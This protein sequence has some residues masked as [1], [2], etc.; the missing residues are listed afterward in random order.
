M[1]VIKSGSDTFEKMKKK[2]R[3]KHPKARNSKRQA[4]HP[5]IGSKVQG[6]IDM[7]SFGK[8]YLSVEGLEEDVVI[9]PEDCRNALGGDWVEVLINGIL[10]KGRLKGQVIC[11]ME[12][13]Q[14]EFV[15]KI[16][17]SDSFAFFI[18]NDD[19]IATHIFIPLKN[20]NG[21]KD[22]DSVLVK[23]QEWQDGDKSPLG[24]VLEVLTGERA[25]EIA[26]KQ[27]LV[28]HGFH[29]QFP[30]GALKL[31][32]S[33]PNSIQSEEVK[34]RKDLRSLLT[35]TIDPADAK[36]FD[37]ALSYRPL[38]DKGFE[39]GVHIAD[40]SHYVPVGSALDEEAYKRST[41]VYL[42]DRVCPMLPET[43]SNEL[44]SLRP[45]E[46]KLTFSVLFKFDANGNRVD[47]QICKS[48]IESDARYTYSE[49]DA[50]IQ[51]GDDPNQEALRALHK[52]AQQLREKRF[53]KGAINFSSEEVRFELDE[54]HKPIGI[55]IKKT[56]EATSLIEE[57]MLL[58][59]RTVAEHLSKV[60]IGKKEL[61]FPY[62]VHDTPNEE[63]LATFAS[64]VS[65][66]GYRLNLNSPRS[67]SQSFN[68][69]LEEAKGKP[70]QQVIE[71]LGIRTMAKAIYSP[72]NIGH[73]GLGFAYYCHFTSPIR[74]YPD[75]MVHRV[76]EEV[77]HGQ[78][79]LNQQ[80]AAQSR[81][82]SDKERKAIEA[83]RE[84][85]KYKQVEYMEQF[86][87]D[88]LDAVI[89]GVSSMGFWAETM[90][91]KCEGMVGIADLSD[92]DVFEFQEEN[93]CLYGLHTGQRL[94]MGDQVKV[95]VV[96]T[97]LEKRNIDF[98]WVKELNKAQPKPKSKP[99]KRAKGT[100]GKK[101]G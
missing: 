22:K 15:G 49:V 32:R 55:I 85:N 20:L 74:R 45:G 3:E 89:T 69:M 62:R 19:K 76:L 92:Y 50:I 86:L 84:A 36:D 77:L 30:E 95:K 82:C 6:I 93:Y 5:L 28:S 57:F 83:E 80:A 61:P 71:Q 17:M 59:N 66:L 58:A 97:N 99:T 87:G 68:N 21:A 38:K 91:Q 14:T 24:T 79:K 75:I 64:F 46:E 67:I 16:E 96:C 37:D 73:Y 23:V 40:V 1:M 4:R 8:G 18:P 52:M 63:K 90:E 7:T 9:Y 26:M 65:R 98:A 39:I 78:P 54:A 51:G 70:E 100:K 94:Q 29:S 41:S 101:K 12:H 42:P 13:G 27:I 81:H 2:K 60:K 31:A 34:K 88:T 56:T 47:Y 53:V 10:K 43:I 44:C 33:L 48:I 11:V 25:N 35:M 72:E